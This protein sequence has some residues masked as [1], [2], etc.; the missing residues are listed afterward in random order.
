MPITAENLRDVL[1]R[2]APVVELAL[3]QL[4]P[5]PV[6]PMNLDGLRVLAQDGQDLADV[7]KQVIDQRNLGDS[8]EAFLNARGIELIPRSEAETWD[9]NIPPLAGA[10]IP[11]PVPNDFPLEKIGGFALRASAFRCRIEVDGVTEGSGAFISNRLVLTAA[12]VIDKVIAAERQA[13]EDGGAAPALPK[14]TV[15]TSDGREYEAR[16]VWY[17]PVHDSERNGQLPPAAEVD[18]HRDAALLRVGLPLGLSYGYCTLPEPPVDWVGSRL[19]TLVHY[20]QGNIRGLTRGRVL[21]DGLDDIRLRHDV[22]TAGGSSGGLAFDRDLQFIGIHQ[23][24]WNDFRKLVPHAVFASAPGFVDAIARDRPRRYL[25]SLDDDI[26]G[27]LIIGRGQFFAGLAKMVEEPASL[28][29]GIWVRRTDTTKTTGLSFSFEMLRAFLK[30]RI[31]PSDPETKH[32]CFQIATD[33]EETDLIS[34]LALEVL[35]ALAAGAAPG[36]RAGE[37]SDVAEAR[38]RAVRLAQD[39][40]RRAADEGATF[41]LFFEPPP[42]GKLSDSARTQFE[43]LA[44]WLVTHRNLRLVL[45]GF[46][47]YALAP[48]KFQ[49]AQEADTAR[50]PGLLVDPL[51]RFTDADVQVTLQAMLSDLNKEDNINPIIMQDLV[52]QVTNG[53]DDQ[54]T[55]VYIFDELERAVK[56][57]RLLVKLRTGVGL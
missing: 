39:L 15:K 5:D 57:I 49:R 31:R 48:L 20:P 38:D 12:H 24:R 36:V 45:V 11:E 23:G 51:G 53:L 2:H 9:Q 17:S 35:G 28:M 42:D 40:Q 44:E 7:L 26:D 41:W 14:I 33:L 25:W 29:R 50:K 8:V 4:F 56:R 55:G 37:T 19:M 27:Q 10:A 32:L 52:Q 54:S 46:E 43:H 21:R 22:D 3:E 18:K 34:T 1:Q 6:R 16:C 30:N 47:Q 13:E